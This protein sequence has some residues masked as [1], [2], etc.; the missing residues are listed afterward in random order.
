[1]KEVSILSFIIFF[2]YFFLG[3]ALF[4][5]AIHRR[6]KALFYLTASF[7][8][9]A[10]LFLGPSLLI[11]NIP[12]DW[13]I[14]TTGPIKVSLIPLTYLF[15][16]TLFKPEKK[17][18]PGNLW[19]FVPFVLD[20][21]LTFYVATFRIDEINLRAPLQ[22]NLLGTTWDGNFY[23]TLL[24]TTARAISLLQAFFYSA[25]MIPRLYNYISSQKLEMSLINYRFFNWTK[26]VIVLFILV[27]FFEG[28]ALLGIY[29][30]PIVFG[31]ALLFLVFNAVYLFLYVINFRPH[32]I[33]T[34]QLTQTQDEETENAPEIKDG[35]DTNKWLQEFMERELYL[36]PELTLQKT[37]IELNIAK[38]KLPKLIQDEGH[39]NF[40]SF[41]NHYRVIK[42]KALLQDLPDSRVVESVIT[43]SGFKSRSTFFR[44]FKEFT[45]ITPGEYWQ[46]KRPQIKAQTII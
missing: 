10:I 5:Y 32:E 29:Q 45:G 8:L 3:G 23:Y 16:E 22:K 17:F 34:M 31:A 15:I 38:Y 25:A 36:N 19:H 43:E 28:A 9:R 1:M 2:I 6:Q 7:V 42:T 13:T 41:V 20:F 46:E 4:S 44:V 14:W 30:F 40:Y 35:N 26:G 27:G 39:P 12:I 11:Y 21:M 33:Y 37:S 18:R 24:A